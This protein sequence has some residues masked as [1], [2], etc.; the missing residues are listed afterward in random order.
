MPELWTVVHRVK[1]V[2]RRGNALGAGTLDDALGVLDGPA[3]PPIAA[4]VHD[5]AR[6]SLVEVLGDAVVRPA[7]EVLR[8]DGRAVVVPYRLVLAADRLASAG[9]EGREAL[10]KATDGAT[11]TLT[12]YLLTMVAARG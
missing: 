9:P 1:A 2:L 8:A 4:S 11:P 10:V 6:A 5:R 3:A 7:L 12:A